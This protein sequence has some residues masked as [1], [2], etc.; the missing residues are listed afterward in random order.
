MSS[1]FPSEQ[2][3]HSNS[4]DATE[5]GQLELQWQGPIYK[6]T[7]SYI[8]ECLERRLDC[9]EH[10]TIQKKRVVRVAVELLQNLHHHASP[11]SKSTRF[12]VSNLPN[13]SWSILAENELS[14][15]QHH[16]LARR[17]NDLS[18]LSPKEWRQS[19]REKLT[20]GS[21]SRHGGGGMGLIEI[22]RKAQG[23][24]DVTFTSTPDQKTLVR[25]VAQIQTNNEFNPIN[26]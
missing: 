22:L 2:K 6:H 11:T 17:W 23:L 7:I 3:R 8:L 13:T 16:E 10:S 19:Q 12:Q 15:E 9:F 18:K 25:I 26:R 5:F 20:S 4:E 1:G 21:R 14:E 24:V